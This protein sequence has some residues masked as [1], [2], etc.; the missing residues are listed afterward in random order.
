MSRDKPTVKIIAIARDECAY[1]A[2]WIFHHLYKGFAEIEIL[3]NKTQD[4]SCELVNEIAQHYPQVSYTL[5]DFM[6]WVPGKAYQKFQQIAYAMTVE[7][8]QNSDSSISH[9]MFL[10][11]DEFWVHEDYDIGISDYL[12]DVGADRPIAFCWLNEV[13]SPEP[14]TMIKP[15]T[16]GTPTTMVKSVFPLNCGIKKVRVHQPLLK[17]GKYI[18]ADGS[19]FE[20]SPHQSESSTRSVLKPAYVLHRLYRSELEYVSSLYKGLPEGGLIPLKTN[21]YGFPGTNFSG[22]YCDKTSK[23][24]WGNYAEARDAFLDLGNIHEITASGRKFVEKRAVQAIQL[25][26]ELLPMYPKKILSLFS[27]VCINGVKD[28]VVHYHDSVISAN[29]EHVEMIR[30]LA[31]A[32]ESF[33]ISEAKRIMLKAKALRPDGP[34]I[35]AKIDEY[36]KALIKN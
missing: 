11:I 29:S 35:N 12:C 4:K 22:S 17:S 13:A 20:E 3:I 23:E 26:P 28:A 30:D 15:T 34:M 9:I 32:A 31:I 2:E 21:R 33:D 5:T 6:Q 1:L 25:L 10:D 7:K 24:A 36:N 14:F 27:N 18:F 19:R 16:Y 8:T